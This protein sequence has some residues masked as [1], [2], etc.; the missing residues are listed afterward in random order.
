ME[1]C[2]PVQRVDAATEDMRHEKGEPETTHQISDPVCISWRG[3]DQAAPQERLFF[4][5]THKSFL[6][7]PAAVPSRDAADTKEASTTATPWED[8]SKTLSRERAIGAAAAHAPSPLEDGQPNRNAKWHS[9]HEHGRNERER[10]QHHA[11]SERP[12]N[13]CRGRELDE[14]SNSGGDNSGSPIGTV[15]HT[16]FFVYQLVESRVEI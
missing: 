4:S 6:S 16:C 9:F 11:P 8:P 1:H 13:T 10:L 3:I 7:T 5:T 12:T 15:I 2:A 14:E